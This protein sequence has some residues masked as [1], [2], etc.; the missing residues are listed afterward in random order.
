V[1]AVNAGTAESTNMNREHAVPLHHLHKTD[2]HLIE[3]TTSTNEYV[4]VAHN[5]TPAGC[6]RFALRGHVDHALAPVLHRFGA[7]GASLHA[8]HLG[9]SF[10]GTRPRSCVLSAQRLS[11]SPR[12]CQRERAPL[13]V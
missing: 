5:V 1:A 13:L 7:H 9:T 3:N 2:E 10:G 4:L 6:R 11:L 12:P 8:H